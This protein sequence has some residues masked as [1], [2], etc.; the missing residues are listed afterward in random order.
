MHRMHHAYAD[1]DKDPHSPKFSKNVF[2]MMYKTWLQFR[3][4]VQDKAEIDPKFTKNIPNWT[5]MER[6]ADSW[7]ARIGWMLF[8]VGFYVMFATSWWMFL[9]I[10]VHVFIN[11][12]HG[13]IINWYAHIY[14]KAHHEVNDTSKNLL[15][16]DFLMLGESYHNNHHKFG[17]RAN[18]GVKWYEFDPVYPFIRAFNSIG[19]IRLKANNDLN[20][21]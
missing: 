20:Y 9:L 10:P 16:I 1:T 3:A 15:P 7:G 17:G 18:F 14:G 19:I 12:V 5:F 8:Y 6:L 2:D 21:M 11:P 4:I 13:A